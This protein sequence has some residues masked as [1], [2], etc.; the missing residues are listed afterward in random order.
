MAYLTATKEN[1]QL[2]FDTTKIS[3]G[4]VKSGY[5]TFQQSWSRRILRS[6]QLDPTQGGNWT[7][8]N[9]VAQDV[10][11]NL[12]GFTL[13]N[14]RN[15]IVFLVGSG[16]LNGSQRF[17][18]TI[19]FFYSNATSSTK[20][21][22]F[23]LMSDIFPGSP[24]I[25][26]YTPAGVITFNSLQPP[27]NVVAQITA[28]PPD[29][30][31]IGGRM[32]A[33]YAGGSIQR[34]QLTVPPDYRYA[35]ADYIYDVPLL[36][37]VEYAAFLPWS[38]GAGIWDFSAGYQGYSAAYAVLEGAYGRVGGMSFMLG[39]SAG[40]TL[41]NATAGGGVP[42]GASYTGLPTDRYPTALIILTSNLPMPFN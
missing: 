14:A 41:S 30:T 42:A 12:F 23:D 32:I 28:P 17:G 22:C 25:K 33:P 19:T 34:R 13:A 7:P 6:A 1:G 20:Y 8:V 18:N 21:Y 5:M 36:A 27:L 10:G 37:G 31:T 16:T 9:E 26:T 29:P 15:P 38:R 3:Y 4:L 11:D 35:Q 24:Y 39:A 2:L 40:T